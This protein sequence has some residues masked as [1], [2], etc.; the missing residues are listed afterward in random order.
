MTLEGPGT[1]P[2]SAV[3]TYNAA[4]R[5]ATLDPTAE[6]LA[7]A[8]TYTVRLTS[9]ITDTSPA[10]NALVPYFSWSFTTAAEPPPPPPP[11]SGIAFRSPARR[12]AATTTSLVILASSPASSLATC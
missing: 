4:S 12:T 10:A 6:L 11:G 9:G 1:T 3:V 8:T 7:D 2:V 5:T